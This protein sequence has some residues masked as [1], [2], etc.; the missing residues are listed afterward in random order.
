MQDGRNGKAPRRAG[1]QGAALQYERAKRRVRLL[2]VL[3][4]AEISLATF[5]FVY[6]VASLAGYGLPR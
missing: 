1:L 4:W 5:V 6:L 3:M 2:T